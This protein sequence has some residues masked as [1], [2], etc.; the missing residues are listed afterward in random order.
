MDHGH[1]GEPNQAPLATAAHLMA[2]VF[3]VANPPEPSRDGLGT[4]DHETGGLYMG[5]DSRDSVT[6][7]DGRIRHTKNAYV[8]G[9]ALFPTIG[10]PNPMLTGVALA[11]R[12]GDRIATPTAWSGDP[13]FQVLFNGFDTAGWRMTTI[14]NQPPNRSNP[15]TMRVINGHARN[16]SWETTWAFSGIQ[17]PCRLISY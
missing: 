17:H 5:S 11:R 16:S 6:L 12:L 2:K 7:L 1:L 9:P 10:S 3:G 13:G 15:G 14:R 4:T 8:V